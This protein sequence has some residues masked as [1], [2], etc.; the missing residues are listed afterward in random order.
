LEALGERM[1]GP[2]G[3]FGQKW[4]K[5]CRIGRGCWFTGRKWW[6]DNGAVTV[7]V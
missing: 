2:F 3:D 4:E 5:K 1:F 7:V 6:G